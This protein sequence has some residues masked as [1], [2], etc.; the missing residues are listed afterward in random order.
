MRRATGTSSRKLAW[1]LALVAVALLPAAADDGLDDLL[2]AFQVTPLG[3]QRPTPFKLVALD[4]KPVSLD[5]VR[6]RAVML[7]FWES[8]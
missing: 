2:S 7:Y 4:G 5:D 6:G 8:T 3:D 1:A